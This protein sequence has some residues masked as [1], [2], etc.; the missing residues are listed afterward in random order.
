MNYIRH[1]SEIPVSIREAEFF[2]EGQNTHLWKKT[3]SAP[4]SRQILPILAQLSK[5]HMVYRLLKNRKRHCN[6]P[7]PQVLYK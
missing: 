7:S 1:N 3:H 2:L 6:N 5:V 4:F